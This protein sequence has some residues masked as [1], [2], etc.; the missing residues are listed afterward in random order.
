MIFSGDN[1]DAIKAVVLGRESKLAAD[2]RAIVSEVVRFARSTDS[3]GRL[4]QEEIRMR[5]EAGIASSLTDSEMQNLPTVASI[6]RAVEDTRDLASIK[7]PVKR[8]E[9]YVVRA[10]LLVELA[11]VLKTNAASLRK[12]P[13][14]AVRLV[15]EFFMSR[16]PDVVVNV[17][18]D[19]SFKLGISSVAAQLNVW[20]LAS[21]A[22]SRSA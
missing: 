19:G 8:A 3:L 7:D 15:R 18:A 5:P 4:V 12:N 22:Q 13:G 11:E 6:L 21:E 10:M 14:E 17:N 20:R 1:A 9:A 2:E 16:L